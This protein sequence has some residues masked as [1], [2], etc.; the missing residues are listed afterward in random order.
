M[1]LPVSLIA[2]G[3]QQTPR[4]CEN[5]A[6]SA[7]FVNRD[8]KPAAQLRPIRVCIRAI[9]SFTSNLRRFISAIWRL[10]IDGRARAS[11]ISDSSARW[12]LSS[13]ARCAA[14]DIAGGLLSQFVGGSL[15]GRSGR[16]PGTRPAICHAIREPRVCLTTGGAA[17]RE[18]ARSVAFSTRSGS[19]EKYRS[20]FMG[21]VVFLGA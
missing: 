16:N 17:G 15:V 1:W 3:R 10:S 19:K 8:L 4:D 12:R 6:P 9:S 20:F 5:R 11:I 13:S 21:R 2:L 7:Y 14:L 18:F